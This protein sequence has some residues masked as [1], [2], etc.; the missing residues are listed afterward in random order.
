MKWCFASVQEDMRL[1]EGF[2]CAV[3]GEVSNNILYYPIQ[4]RQQDADWIETIWNCN[5]YLDF[6]ICEMCLQGHDDSMHNRSAD[7]WLTMKI[8]EYRKKKR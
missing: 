4:M 5:P 7:T 2:P 3:C 8:E 1:D 6:Y